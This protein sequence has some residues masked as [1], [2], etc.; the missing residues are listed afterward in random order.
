MGL[1]HSIDSVFMSS[2]SV[3]LTQSFLLIILHYLGH[4]HALPGPSPPGINCMESLETWPK[5]SRGETYHADVVT[6]EQ[7]LRKLNLGAG[8]IAE[9]RLASAKESW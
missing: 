4:A 3:S 9:C 2:H 1:I 5:H 6:V 7:K 8:I